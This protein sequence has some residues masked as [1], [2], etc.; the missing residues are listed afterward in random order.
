MLFIFWWTPK[1]SIK[2]S[3]IGALKTE[4]T[5]IACTRMKWV[6]NIFNRTDGSFGAPRVS[7]YVCEC[8]CAFPW[9][10]YLLIFFRRREWLGTIFKLTL[11]YGEAEWGVWGRSL[12]IENRANGNA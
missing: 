5:K 6:V 11:A 3:N 4:Q 2:A 9:V 10:F 1:S 8:V 7:L 12:K